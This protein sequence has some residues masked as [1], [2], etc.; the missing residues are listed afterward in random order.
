MYAKDMNQS[1]SNFHRQL[2]EAS[3]NRI[4]R[5]NDKKKWGDE[6]MVVRDQDVYSVTP[7][8]VY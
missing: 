4:K 3:V 7:G 8:V 2:W 1:M 6:Y 5:H